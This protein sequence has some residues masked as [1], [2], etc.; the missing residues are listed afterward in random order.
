MSR[1][2][3]GYKI[4][5]ITGS[6]ALFAIMLAG[7]EHIV[8][9]MGGPGANRI[10]AA[11]WAFYKGDTYS[12]GLGTYN[13][14]REIDAAAIEQLKNSTPFQMIFGRGTCNGAL[15]T[16]GLFHEYHDYTDPNRMFHN[17]W[18]RV[19]YEW[20]AIGS[21][22]WLLF[23]GSIIAYAY[24]GWS[25]DRNGDAK[26][27]LVYLPSFLV[28]LSGENILAGA[29]SAVSVG[30]LY[31]IALAS[32]SVRD[33]EKRRSLVRV[34]AALALARLRRGR[35]RPHWQ[36]APSGDGMSLS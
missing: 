25:M 34:R 12:S 8:N 11:L 24:R 23:I 31:T 10:T 29:G 22:C 1:A 26:A 14:R 20:G 19:I 32:L 35:A 5:S 36:V 17:E 6:V 21:V 28:G 15:V 2:R 16:G 27:L 3:F 33:T 7:A 9:A 4:L 18:M 30:F 13:F